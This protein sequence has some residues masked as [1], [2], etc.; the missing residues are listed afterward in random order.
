MT[1]VYPNTCSTFKGDSKLALEVGYV[2]VEDSVY[3]DLVE[4]KKKWDNGVIVDDPTYPERKRQQEEEEERRR[5][6][7]ELKHEVDIRKQWFDHDYRMYNEKLQRFAALGI[8]EMIYDA[9][10][11]K[12]YVTLTDLYTEAE[13][14]RD[15]IHARENTNEENG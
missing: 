5:K 8:E 13:V 12:T 3:A 7:E 6:A 11:D 9:F 1:F 2:E 10:R 14:V 4:T 15:E